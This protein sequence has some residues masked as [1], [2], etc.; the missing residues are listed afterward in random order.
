MYNFLN[1]NSK[2]DAGAVAIYI[3]TTLNCINEETFTLHGIESLSLNVY[4]IHL[5]E[6]LTVGVIYWYPSENV[7]NFIKDFLAC[8]QKLTAKKN[9]TTFLETST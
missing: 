3:S 2:R 6:N 9:S 1:V 8:V 5:Q 4:P 7:D